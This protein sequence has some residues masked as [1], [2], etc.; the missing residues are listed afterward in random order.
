MKRLYS[1]SISILCFVLFTG[2]TNSI[3]AQNTRIYKTQSVL[4]NLKA[5]HP[6]ILDSLRQVER[7]IYQY[8]AIGTNEVV[9]IPVVFH[10]IHNPANPSEL[11]I[12]T[13]IEA[14]LA[15]LN[16]D[17]IGTSPIQ[18]NFIAQLA[19]FNTQN[20]N[21]TGVRFCLAEKEG[22]SGINY[23]TTLESTWSDDA[24][25]LAAPA[26]NPK[27]YLNIWIGNLDG[28]AG[29]AYQPGMAYDT[30]LDGVVIDYQ[31]VDGSLSDYNLH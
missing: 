1:Y 21:D 6:E 24:I 10:I 3:A 23:V 12:K 15:A 26:W 25:K 16:R 11:V 2:I 14:Q 13:A 30:A 19:G 17:F 5:T 4:K 29:Y 28:F 20:A 22:V 7:H 8:K 31:Y 27:Q 9:T 18:E